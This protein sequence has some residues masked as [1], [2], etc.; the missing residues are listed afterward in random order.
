MPASRYILVVDDEPQIH[1]FLRPTLV[2]AGFT[3][4]SAFTGA[5]ALEKIR[6]SPP[7]LIVLDLGLTDMDGSDVLAAIRQTSSVPVVILSARDNEAEKVALLNAGA[8]DYVSK[9]FG[10]DELIAR[11]NTALRHAVTSAGATVVFETGDLRVDTLAHRVTLKGEPIKLTPREYDL[12]HL[13]ARHAGRMLTHQHI[14]HEVWGPTHGAHAQYLRVF[15]SRLRQKIEVDAAQPRLLLTEAGV[16]YRLAAPA[17]L[18]T[19][20]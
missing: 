17:N 19:H 6:V 4:A 18:A 3:V 12:L 20:T 14:L 11:I 1:R 13:L 15:V 2:A 16:G 9:P 10:V 7:E 5:E 8:D